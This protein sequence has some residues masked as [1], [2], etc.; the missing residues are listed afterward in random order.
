MGRLVEL[1]TQEFFYNPFPIYARAEA[2]DAGLLQK[3]ATNIQPRELTVTGNVR[4]V[5]E[6]K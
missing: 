2:E 3:T 4:A 5:Y 6:I 1:S